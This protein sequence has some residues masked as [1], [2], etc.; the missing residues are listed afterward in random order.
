MV[1]LFDL[2][3][4]W[5]ETLNILLSLDNNRPTLEFLLGYR[6]TFHILAEIRSCCSI[7]SAN[8]WKI[9]LFFM[10]QNSE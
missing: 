10:H 6:Y 8:T 2:G 3:E 7:I 5:D 1:H 9:Y 4:V